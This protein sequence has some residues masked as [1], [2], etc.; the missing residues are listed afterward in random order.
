MLVS[1]LRLRIT[2]L[3][4]DLSESSIVAE[5]LR[6]ELAKS[7]L[8][9]DSNVEY[10]SEVK[11]TQ[12]QLEATNSSLQAE[13]RT[14]TTQIA[15]LSTQLESVNAIK[16]MMETRVTDFDGRNQE[17]RTRNIE[18]ETGFK[19][20]NAELADYRSR[21]QSQLEKIG[22]LTELNEQYRRYI[23]KLESESLPD[24]ETPRAE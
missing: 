11:A 10:V 6:T 4:S 24:S 3:E 20:S 14:L 21:T 13:N 12:R 5:N 7:S 8:K 1:E 16:S 19:T 15:T 2:Q 18:L 9:L 23:D 22:Q 17:L